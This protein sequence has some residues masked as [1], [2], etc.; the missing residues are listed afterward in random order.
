MA[1][2]GGRKM[3]FDVNE[4]PGATFGGLL[5][6][7]TNPAVMVLAAEALPDALPNLLDKHQGLLL[8]KCMDEMADEP[9]LLLRLS[10]IFGTEVE[11]YHETLLVISHQEKI[12]CRRDVA[13][14]CR[15]DVVEMSLR[16]H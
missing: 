5:T 12:R 6:V 16:C 10:R 11:S 4:L 14:A 9:E 8:I 3:Q 15:R 13:E 2:T 7:S 1:G